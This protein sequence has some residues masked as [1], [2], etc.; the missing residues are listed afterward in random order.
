MGI[1]SVPPRRGKLFLN[2]RSAL[3]ADLFLASAIGRAGASPCEPVKVH[4]AII[5]RHVNLPSIDYRWIEFVEEKLNTP[6][7]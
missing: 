2:A 1:M 5:I 6:S 7:L 4:P 3:G